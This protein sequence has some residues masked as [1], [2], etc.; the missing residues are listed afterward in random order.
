MLAALVVVVGHTVAVWGHPSLFWG[1][2]GRWLHELD[3][4]AH[5]ATFYRDIYWA[6]PP[7]AMWLL[8]G[9]TRLVGADLVQVWSLTALLAATIALTYGAVVARLVEG[10]LAVLVAVTGMALGVAYSQQGSAPLSAG[11]YTPAVPVAML[12]LLL[13]LVA[14]L[15]DWSRPSLAGAML[16]GALGGLGILA[17]HDVWFAAAWLALAAGL[18]TAPGREGRMARLVAAGGGFVAIAGSGLATLAVQ[19]GTARLRDILTGFGHVEEFAGINYPDLSLITVDAATFGLA[20]ASIAVL[21]RVGGAWRS[22]SAWGLALVG[23]SLAVAA[24]GLWLWQAE[25]IAAHMLAQGVPALPTS[26]ESAL[27]PIAG[28]AGSRLRRAFGVLRFQMLRHLLPLFLPLSAL[29]TV[30]AW[31]ERVPDA[32]RWRLV[33]ILLVACLALR[34][35][36]MVSFTEWSVLMVELPVYV[37]AA[38]LLWPALRRP[39][40]R[41]LQLACALLL[42]V[43]ARMHWRLGYGLGSRRGVLAAVETPRGPAR[44]ARG[45]AL[46]LT[47]LRTLADAVDPSRT[48]PIYAFGYSGGLSYFTGRPS[49]DPLTQGFRLSLLPTADSAFRIVAAVKSRL[50]L[51]DNRAFVDGVPSPRFAPWRW[52]PEMVPSPYQR[53]DRPLFDRLLRGCQEVTRPGVRSA[54]FTMYDCAPGARRMS[55][56]NALAR[57]T[58]A[59]PKPLATTPR[60]ATPKVTAPHAAPR[61]PA[62]VASPAHRDG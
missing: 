50:L 51:V 6:F 30:V 4:V 46:D 9:L 1:D 52:M 40:V 36:R 56:R 23:L 14:F 38:S 16:V 7:L 34:A 26:F 12:C 15:R 33:V 27:Q 62:L 25:R 59:R 49:V 28:D 3:S 22:R 24:M 29:L 2:N 42:V 47:Y 8:G 45:L 53:V 21:A 5:G 32:R 35:R 10:R 20:V 43:A 11:M 54:I 17:K 13:Q 18:L 48:R 61:T 37:A 44:L 41:T 39:G 31:R 58:T 60:P 55:A 57:G 19:H